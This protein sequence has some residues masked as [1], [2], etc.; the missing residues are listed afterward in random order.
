MIPESEIPEC[1]ELEVKSKIRK[2]F[3]KHNFLKEYS[4]RTY[5]I[6]SC[7]YKHQLK[8][9]E[10]NGCEYILF[11]IDVYFNEYSFAVEIDEK[12]HTDRDFIFEQKGQKTLEK[13]LKFI[14]IQA[15]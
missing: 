2:I 12:G 8:K 6:D 13:K 10:K 9:V 11:R 14:R 1:P 7:F 3:K 15:M 5:K 4:V